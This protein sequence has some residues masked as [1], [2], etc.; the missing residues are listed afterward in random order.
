MIKGIRIEI[1]KESEEKYFL[2]IYLI[3]PYMV[4]D[5]YLEPMI[6]REDLYNEYFNLSVKDYVMLLIDHGA[7]YKDYK[8]YFSKYKD[9]EKAKE[10]MEAR[11]LLY[12]LTEGSKW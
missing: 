10:T 7:R 4:Y 8:V 1:Y 12:K 3:K 5:E 2:I 11:F 6:W 9:A